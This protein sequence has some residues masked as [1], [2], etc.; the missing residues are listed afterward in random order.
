VH[1]QTHTKRD[2]LQFNLVWNQYITS[3]AYANRVVVF[4]GRLKDEK[5]FTGSI[6][7]EAILSEASDPNP[8]EA[9]AGFKQYTK[10]LG[11][12]QKLKNIF[13]LLKTKAISYTKKRH[14]TLFY[15]KY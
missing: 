2:L 13:S 11:K 4:I 12:Y 5:G 10:K 1:Q 6:S 3:G 9:S 7:N 8:T 14:K 15:L